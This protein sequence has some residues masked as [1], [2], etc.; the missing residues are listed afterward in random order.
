MNW[1]HQETAHRGGAAR[2]VATLEPR[3]GDLLGG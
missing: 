3:T 2:E 1:F